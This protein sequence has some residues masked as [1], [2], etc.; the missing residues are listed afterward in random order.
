MDETCKECGN[1]VT[2]LDNPVWVIENGQKL[3]FHNDWH[4]KVNGRQCWANY[5]ESGEK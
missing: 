2:L 1:P 3:Y 4:T 5:R